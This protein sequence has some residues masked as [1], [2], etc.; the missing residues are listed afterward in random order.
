M[1]FPANIIDIVKE[2]HNLNSLQMVHGRILPRS[3]MVLICRLGVQLDSYPDVSLGFEYLLDMETASPYYPHPKGA[4]KAT[5]D[6]DIVAA[7][8]NIIQF[9]LPNGIDISRTYKGYPS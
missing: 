6:N 3:L 9:K 2:V 8:F 7:T 1:H 4:R 5:L